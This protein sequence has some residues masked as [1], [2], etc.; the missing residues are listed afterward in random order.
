VCRCII[1]EN[2]LPG[3]PAS[4]WNLMARGRE[5]SGFATQIRSMPNPKSEITESR[6]TQVAILTG[7]VT[8]IKF[9]VGERKIGTQTAAFWY[10]MATSSVKELLS[11]GPDG[12]T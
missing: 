12:E 1:C 4:A 2:Q 8:A 5:R 9:S 7:R 11:A 3:T 6:I 10:L